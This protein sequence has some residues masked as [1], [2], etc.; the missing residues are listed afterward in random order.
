MSHSGK[1]L[2]KLSIEMDSV[3]KF[4]I[5]TNLFRRYVSQKYDSNSRKLVLKNT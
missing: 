2:K 4:S 5:T 3:C 1:K